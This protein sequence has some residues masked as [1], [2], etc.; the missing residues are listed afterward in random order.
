MKNRLAVLGLVAA[1]LMVSGIALSSCVEFMDGF[2]EG[3]QSTRYGQYSSETDP[4][5]N[6][7]LSFLKGI[8][9]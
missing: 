3:Y 9:K 8:D 1:L 4:L 6:K 2:V 7:E 5:L